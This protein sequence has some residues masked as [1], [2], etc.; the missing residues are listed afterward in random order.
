MTVRIAATPS[1]VEIEPGQPAT[2]NVAVTNASDVI[3]AYGVEIFG[4]D[5]LWVETTP[6][7]LSLFP[8]DVDTMTVR[9][10]LPA[11]VPSA[12]RTLALNVRSENDPTEFALAQVGL[13][14]RP[15]PGAKLNV[16]PNLVTGGRAATFGMLVHNQGNVPMTVTPYGVDPE[17]KGDFAF[18]PVALTVPAGETAI[19][20]ARFSGGRA[21]FG[22]L[23]P[24]PLTL[25]ITTE[26]GPKESLVTFLQRPRISRLFLMLLGLLLAASVFAVVLNTAFN[27]VAQQAEE[28]QVDDGVVELAL[29][30]PNASNAAGIPLDPATLEGSVTSTTTSSGVPGVEVGLYRSDDLTAP[31]A[32]AVTDDDGAFE[33][34]GLA[35]GDY[36]LR[37]SGAGFDPV[38][39]P[40]ASS[41]ADAE[42]VTADPDDD[43][44][45]PIAIV[46][47]GRPGSIGGTVVADDP[48]GAVARL[49]VQSQL[50]EAAT[51]LV[52]EI[53]V[54]ADGSFLFENVPAPAD[55]TLIVSQDGAATD[56]RELDLS[57]AEE[58]RGI[59]IV[60]RPADGLV[61]GL[62]L[63]EA[64]EPLGGA[65][66]TA[67]DGVNP[68]TTVSLT[69]GTV[70]SFSIRNLAVPGRYTITVQAEGYGTE[71][72]SIVLLDNDPRPYA[73]SPL[74]IALSPSIGELSGTVRLDPIGP[75]GP[76]PS[77]GVTVS[78]TGPDFDAI[79]TTI[80]SADQLGRFSFTDVPVPG[81]FTLTFRTDGYET[82]VL[83]VQLDGR[84]GVFAIDDLNATLLASDGTLSGTVR[85]DGPDGPV[86]IGRARIVVSDGTNEYTTY[87]ADEPTLGAYE[88]A[89]IPPGD[90]TVRAQFPG[91]VE[92][93]VLERLDAGELA[94]VPLQLGPVASISGTVVFSDD[95]VTAPH[96]AA[97]AAVYL[98]PIDQFGAQRPA[99][100][101][102]VCSD[103][104]G[105]F[106][107]FGMD[108]GERFVV[109]VYTSSGSTRILD[110]AQVLS[111]D[112]VAV[113]LDDSDRRLVIDAGEFD[114]AD[115]Q[116]TRGLP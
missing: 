93:V 26:T 82:Q 19:V 1:L 14:V 111:F 3:D 9:I 32:S 94:S 51:A 109:A 107:F 100:A 46:I 53:D 23:T 41:P 91:A 87:S 27:E 86:P 104:N 73:D 55:Y 78:A 59:E 54:S 33:L 98:I 10:A 97:D 47:G 45:A 39:Y 24:R 96:R 85:I 89:A 68:V 62:V 18:E 63:D 81:T 69:N 30:D 43:D 2:F 20:R 88:I 11:D 115:L 103:A 99:D 105:R 38:W 114:D 17:A 106:S 79:T 60:L 113:D 31:V 16:D 70:G 4:V 64:G 67:T 37:V 42:P 84:G 25:G 112:G 83:L 48:T 71:T 13:T 66:V 8:G 61:D 108:G 110:S 5:P 22:H 57:A 34:G 52:A 44:A 80:S 6:T 92:T 36:L 75:V 90:Y 29:Q 40:S 65:I 21:W 35:A 72:T 116:C 15:Q 101:Q 77:G 58:L 76:V 95:S 102:L 12:R 28:N 49:V 7:R 56:R 50:D 74:T